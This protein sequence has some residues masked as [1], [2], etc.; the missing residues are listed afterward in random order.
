MVRKSPL[1]REILQG[2]HNPA[3]AVSK[4][5]PKT[6]KHP[7]Q[8]MLNNI[9]YILI[10]YITRSSITY[11]IKHLECLKLCIFGKNTM[12]SVNTGYFINIINIIS[13]A[14]YNCFQY[15]VFIVFTSIYIYGKVND[16]LTKMNNFN[17]PLPHEYQCKSLHLI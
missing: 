12:L 16:T 15:H 10:L 5:N 8:G 9:N 13:T 7:F 1:I 17:L 6:K 4:L 14:V 2:Y 3:V 11:N